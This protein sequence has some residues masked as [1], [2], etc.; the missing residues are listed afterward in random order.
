M[1]QYYNLDDKTVSNEI[2]SLFPDWKEDRETVAVLSPND[3]DALL[4][5]GYAMK[6]AAL[7]RARLLV[8]VLCD[9]RSGYTSAEESWSIAET[10]RAEMI[11][12]YETVGVDHGSIIRF[13]YPDLSLGAHAGW[14]LPGVDGEKGIFERL[15]KLLRQREVT[16][17]LLPGGHGAHP[18][19]EA[20][21]RIGR[22]TGSLAGDAIIADAG[23]PSRIRSFLAYSVWGDFSPVD[24][25]ANRSDAEENGRNARANRAIKAPSSLEA[26]IRE[27][28][29]KFASQER[30][31]AKLIDAR[32]QR[33]FEGSAIELY[34]SIKPRQPL[35]YEPYWKS[36]REIDA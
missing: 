29:G 35:C 8:L 13:E 34:L 26:E 30:N 28:I 19:H 18:D 22:F 24:A 15:L 23:K 4:G 32:K 3:H 17:L 5:A 27:S 1:F 12:A 9:G 36:I 20:A 6:A 11:E 7:H 14:I 25:L 21:D 33:E 31:I 16:R 2:S 10:R